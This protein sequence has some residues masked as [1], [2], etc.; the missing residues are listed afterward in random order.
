MGIRLHV[1]GKMVSILKYGPADMCP[2][3]ALSPGLNNSRGQIAM[4]NKKLPQG[5]KITQ[6]AAW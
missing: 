4:G 5:N 2:N 1:P 3:V 6:R